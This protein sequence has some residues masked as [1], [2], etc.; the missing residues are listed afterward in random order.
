MNFSVD[1]AKGNKGELLLLKFLFTC[2]Y[3]AFKNEDNSKLS[4]FDIYI[5]NPSITFEVKF[6]YKFSLT[7][8]ICIEH[9]NCKQDKPSGIKI[10]TADFWCHMV[11]ENKIPTMYFARRLEL[12]QFME[13]VEPFKKI[14]GGGDDN[15]NLYIYKGTAIL[16]D[17]GGPRPLQKL[18]IEQAKK[19]FGEPNVL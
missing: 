19:L 2:G 17:F 15:A 14:V 6:D 3:L 7:S 8:N 11:Y 13:D 18:T 12:L 5:K 9:H 1:M 10:S 16:G 4:F